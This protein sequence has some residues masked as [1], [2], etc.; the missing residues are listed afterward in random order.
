MDITEIFTGVPDV[1]REI[2]QRIKND[3]TLF[4]VCMTDKYSAS[5]CN[6]DFWRNRF[7]SKYGV[8]LAK[9]GVNH[10]VLYKLYS[11]QSIWEDLKDATKYDYLEFVKKYFSSDYIKSNKS[12]NELIDIASTNNRAKV[13][14]Y[15]LDYVDPNTTFTSTYTDPIYLGHYKIVKILTKFIKNDKYESYFIRQGFLAAS[16][17]K[18][19]MKTI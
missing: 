18:L 8:N 10:E 2:L 19:R 4:N 1:D 17:V 14:N 16:L 13:L 7:I 3:E 15:I 12:I 6:E 9:Y 11:E 5:I